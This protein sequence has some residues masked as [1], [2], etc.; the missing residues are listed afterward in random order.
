MNFMIVWSHCL[1][2]R[3]PLKD[4][5]G[6]VQ[7]VQCNSQSLGARTAGPVVLFS[8]Q[9]DNGHCCGMSSYPL[10]SLQSRGFHDSFLTSLLGLWQ[11]IGL[12]KSSICGNKRGYN[13]PNPSQEMA[14]SW[15]NLLSLELPR[16]SRKPVYQIAKKE[17]K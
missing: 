15:G 7:G 12:L 9:S 17:Y 11:Q 4:G 6:C 8:L 5:Q 2:P 10:D 1:E 3:F 16:P 13:H 14:L